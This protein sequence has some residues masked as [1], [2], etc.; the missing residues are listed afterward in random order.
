MCT[1]DTLSG[2]WAWLWQ[3]LPSIRTDEKWVWENFLHL[4]KIPFLN[5]NTATEIFL[6]QQV[7][8]QLHSVISFLLFQLLAH[9]QVIKSNNTFI[10][11]K[12]R[13]YFANRTE[14]WWQRAKQVPVVSTDLP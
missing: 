4:R 1:N 8:D 10:A 12:N 5:T 13:K 14:L 6:K 11:Y 7:A 3:L 9:F 2:V